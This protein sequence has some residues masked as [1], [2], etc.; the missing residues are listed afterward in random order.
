MTNNPT[1]RAGLIGY[2]IEIVE[3]VGLAVKP[4]PHNKKYLDT[5]RDKM[6]HE[7]KADA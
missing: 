2:G 5:K 1:K 3:N 7:L 4:N 6:G